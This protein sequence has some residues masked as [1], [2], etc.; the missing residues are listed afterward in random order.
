L[1]GLQTDALADHDDVENK[2]PVQNI[3]HETPSAL[4]DGTTI[5]E[6]SEYRE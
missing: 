2:E 4:L 5:D 3:E 1:Y 6:V